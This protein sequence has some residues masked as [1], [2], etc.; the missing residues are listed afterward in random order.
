MLR[1]TGWG[2]FDPYSLPA[3]A[4]PQKLKAVPGVYNVDN[5]ANAG[6]GT[7]DYSFIVDSKGM[8]KPGPTHS[9]DDKGVF[10][11]PNRQIPESPLRRIARGRSE[12]RR[13]AHPARAR[14]AREET[15]DRRAAPPV[16][17]AFSR[18][19]ALQRPPR[20][21]SGLVDA[22]GRRS[23]TQERRRR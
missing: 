11:S 10:T 12:P 22:P 6:G 19:P 20:L 9:V 15:T 23:I 17:A 3:G 1:H 7:E 13:F 8:V 16:F 4:G 18:A 21:R 2:L 14:F 5:L